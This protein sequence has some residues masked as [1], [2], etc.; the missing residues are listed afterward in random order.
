MTPPIVTPPSKNQSWSDLRTRLGSA[1]ILGAVVLFLTVL[2]GLPFRLLCVVAAAI[3]FQEWTRITR[4][5]ADGGLLYRFSRR[6]LVL[7]L[8]LFIAGFSS[9]ALLVLAAALLFAVIADY[10]TGRG[11]WAIGGLVYA[12][13][14]ALGPGILRGSDDA[15]LISIGFVICVVWAT[16]IFA[17]FAGR[18]FGGPK[19]MPKVSPKKTIS[20]AFGGL[21]AGIL[22]ATVYFWL[23]TGAVDTRLAL[24]AALLSIV[25]QAGDLFESWVKRRFGVKDSG[26]ILPGH[27]GL[28]DR[29]DALVVAVAVAVLIGALSNGLDHPAAAFL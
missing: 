7:V 3:V 4:A 6:A 24:L 25:G 8:A 14:T 10:R 23:V 12:A 13:A 17:Y 18:T 26:R 22:V 20:G 2:G 9:I 16:D 11:R 5:K 29:I 15:G 28:L 21:L 27:G 19:L 1:L